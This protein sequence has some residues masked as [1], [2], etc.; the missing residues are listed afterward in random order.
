MTGHLDDGC[1]VCAE[2]LAAARH[3]IDWLPLSL[4][5]AE[6]ES[7]T[8]ERLL[9][10]IRAPN[11]PLADHRPATVPLEPTDFASPRMIRSAAI[12]AIILIGMGTALWLGVARFQQLRAAKQKPVD[13]QELE[14]ELAEAERALPQ[15]QLHFA[16]FGDPEQDAGV[17]AQLITD[18]STGQCHVF[19]MSLPPLEDER[20]YRLWL[21]TEGD[22]GQDDAWFPLATLPVNDDGVGSAM[23]ESGHGL[24]RGRRRSTEHR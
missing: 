3:A 17:S 14:R 4:Q 22:E 1:A 11:E 23:C 9:E 16:S 6:L 19:A 24:R 21:L 8:R 12:A 7:D 18:Q 13:M 10:R 5:P 20:E 2:H 15:A